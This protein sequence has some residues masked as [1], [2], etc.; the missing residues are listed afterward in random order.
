MANNSVI[1]SSEFDV[2]RITYSPIRTLE[3]GGKVVYLSY[4]KGQ[5]LILQTPEMVAPFG[6]SRWSADKGGPESLSI[7][8]SFKNRDS[9][10]KLETFYERLMALDK[11]LV[12]DGL[13]NSQAW[14]KRRITSREVVENLYTPM[15]RFPK[16]RVTGEVID[17]FPPTFK[18][19]LP[20]KD[21]KI[22]VDTYD[23]SR[24]RIDIDEIVDN[25]KGARVTALIQCVGVWIAGGKFGCSWKVLQLKVSPLE[26]I[27]GYGFVDDDA[28]SSVGGNGDAH[29]APAPPSAAAA[30][31]TPVIEDDD[32]EVIASDG[33]DDDDDADIIAGNCNGDGGSGDE[34]V[35]SPPATEASATTTSGKG[36]KKAV[37]SIK[38]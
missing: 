28:G 27:C 17:K 11:K 6:V 8:L 12:D 37:A 13:E 22:I 31:A 33:D 32:A 34:Q 25:L 29:A 35:P 18:V 4:N 5:R 26:T 16:D 20:M 2:T 15:V 3:N 7:D 19:K 21:G 24:N 14:L 30:T 9:R 10:E 23:S 38:R 1:Q 36:R